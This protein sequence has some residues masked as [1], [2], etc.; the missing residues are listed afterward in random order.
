MYAVL[1]AVFAG[2]AAALSA[3]GIYGVI[4]YSV[5]QRTHEIGVR[6]AFGARAR[7]VI[8]LAVGDSLIRTAL[9]IALGL[10]AAAWLTRFLEGMLFGVTPLDL[11]TFALVAIAFATLAGVASFLPARRAAKVDPLVA[12]RCE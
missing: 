8:R 4:A 10:T 6:M 12:L 9:G 11:P 5:A 2:I 3:I 7:D 1:L